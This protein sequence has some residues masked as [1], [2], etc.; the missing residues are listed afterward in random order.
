VIQTNRSI[1]NSYSQRSHK[2]TQ[3]CAS[4]GCS[5]ESAIV[6]VVLHPHGKI[7]PR[8]CT[9]LEGLLSLTLIQNFNC[10]RKEAGYEMFNGLGTVLLGTTKSHFTSKRIFENRPVF[11]RLTPHSFWCAGT[12]IKEAHSICLC[13][14]RN[15]QG[16]RGLCVQSKA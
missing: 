15:N 7:M 4:K 14:V 16:I 1:P 11:G 6:Q 2:A 13:E 12:E 8:F 10:K 5:Q 9:A 3:T